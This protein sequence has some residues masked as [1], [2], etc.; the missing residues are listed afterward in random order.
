MKKLMM[1]TLFTVLVGC[2]TPLNSN[3]TMIDEVPIPAWMEKL[4]CANLSEL[5]TQSAFL[6]N[7]SKTRR[8]RMNTPTGMQLW[9]GIYQF[10][11]EIHDPLYLLL[12]EKC[13]RI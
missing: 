2:V 6:Y 12:H 3:A 7:M 10:T 8:I 1:A 5:Y 11:A 4:D 13:P 9:N